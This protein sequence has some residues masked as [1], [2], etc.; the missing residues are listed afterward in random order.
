MTRINLEGL[1]AGSAAAETDGLCAALGAIVLD[2]A[3]R[4]DVNRAVV[5]TWHAT[6][7]ATSPA[8]YELTD[9]IRRVAR[10]AGGR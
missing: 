5:A 9:A 4:G 7:R 10:G 8:A 2:S 6:Q 1:R 3:D